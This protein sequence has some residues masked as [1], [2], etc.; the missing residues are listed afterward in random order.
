[1]VAQ[2]SRRTT[3]PEKLDRRTVLPRESFR[4]KSVAIGRSRPSRIV[5]AIPFDVGGEKLSVATDTA[6][7]E[8][9][10]ANHGIT[11]ILSLARWRALILDSVTQEPCDRFPRDEHQDDADD[12]EIHSVRALRP[13]PVS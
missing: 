2:K 5:A 12:R 4:A 1:F 6:S 8:T 10:I 11:R 3:R 7:R 9:V 13:T